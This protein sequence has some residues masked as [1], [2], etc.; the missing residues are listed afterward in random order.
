MAGPLRLYVDTQNRKLV[1][2]NT[3]AADKSFP[4]LVQGEV[5]DVQI[6]FL[7]P[8]GTFSAPYNFV[9]FSG[10]TLKMG[11]MAGEPTG[12]SDTLIAFQD[13]WTAISN[14]FQAEFSLNTV[15]ISNA[16]GGNPTVG[17]TAEIE[18]SEPGDDPVKYFQGSCTIKAAVIDDSGTIPTPASSYVTRNEAN[19][20]YLK[21]VEDNG[22]VW[23]CRSPNGVYARLIGVD[24]N[25]DGID[26]IVIL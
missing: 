9:N 1:Q 26:S 16:L 7:Q 21:K 20:S 6:Y 4:T 3:N 5:P 19:A 14:G 12:G 18:L 15:G 22:I 8:T 13:T 11:I 25:G 2:S 24:N 10:S 17:C 23:E